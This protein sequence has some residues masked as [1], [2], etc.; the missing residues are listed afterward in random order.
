MTPST[1]A[2]GFED[3]LWAAADL[4]RSSLDPAEFKHVVLGLIFL[5]SVSDGDGGPPGL[6]VP[7]EARW[8]PLR[9]PSGQ[10]RLAAR[11]DDAMGALEQANPSL[12]GALPRAFG[13]A[14]LDA[15]RLTALM[16]LLSDLGLGGEGHRA[17]DTLGRV[18]EYFVSRFASA[19]GRGG[20]EF[21]TPSSIVGLLVS[22]L[23]P[24]EGRVYDPC[25]GSGGMFVQS[26]RLL[27]AHG[28]RLDAVRLHGQESNPRTWRMARM[29]LA[30]RGVEADLGDRAA[31]T[32]HQDLHPGLQA[33]HVLANPPFNISRWGGEAL[34]QDPRWTHGV[35]PTGSANFAWLQHILHHLAPQGTAGVVLS[36][37]TLSSTSGGEGEIRR[38]LVQADL[39]D[40]I[41]A[42]PDRLFYATPIPSC[43]WI[44][45]RDKAAAG[46][47]DRRGQLRFIDARGLGRME[48]RVHRVL[49]LPDQARI[50]AAY[51]GWRRADGDPADLDGFCRAV[52]VAQVLAQDAVLTPGR[53]V[54]ACA[55]AAK[56]DD[57]LARLAV[58]AEELAA[59]QRQAA[60]LDDRIAA[61][62]RSL[63]QG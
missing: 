16:D 53:Y 36:N 48:T 27:E 24:F 38:R 39:V 12:A 25:C 57:P 6:V 1:A 23:E 14:G 40:C 45:C 55:P 41:V 51:R 32:L 60:G 7:P 13:R 47:R 11:L 28:G 4:L 52:P 58:L 44:L 33:D 5:K 31:D 19:E 42:L 8:D 20:G 17:R 59:Q 18:Y 26:L 9:A 61:A 50:S 54:G 37:G 10:A 34:A 3:T 35:P 29:N 46:D 15:S 62:L 56:A 2:L 63:G 43:L 22:L 21:Y 49:D 30:L